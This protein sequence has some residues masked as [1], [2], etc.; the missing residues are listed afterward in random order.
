MNTHLTMRILIG[1]KGHAYDH[2][3]SVNMNETMTVISP[4]FLFFSLAHS[5]WIGI[6]IRIHGLELG[7]ARVCACASVCVCVHVVWQVHVDKYLPT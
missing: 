5:F 7:L 4:L 6:G 3:A 2:Y 1:M